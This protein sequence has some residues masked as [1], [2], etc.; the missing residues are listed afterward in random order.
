MK[1]EKIRKFTKNMSNGLKAQG[2]K[3]TKEEEKLRKNIRSS[4]TGKNS[5]GKKNPKNTHPAQKEFERQMKVI[6]SGNLSK[7]GKASGDVTVILDQFSKM[8]GEGMKKITYK[9]NKV[10][11]KGDTATINVTV[12][13]PDL[14]PYMSELQNRMSEKLS[15]AMPKNNEELQNQISELGKEFFNEKFNSK[16]LKYTEKT[17]DVKY[18]KNGK[19]WEMSDE[20]EEFFKILTFGLMN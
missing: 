9:I 6:Q 12:K 11:A 15:K 20:N 13:S 2:I 5:T 1:E 10:E 14:T 8:Y 16:D 3:N 4:R 18:V 19:D 7:F 17:L